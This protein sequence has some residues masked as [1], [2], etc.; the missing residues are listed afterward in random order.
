[1]NK[2]LYELIKDGCWERDL[3]KFFACRPI[4]IRSLL[5][6]NGWRMKAKPGNNKGKHDV[7]Y[8][9]PVRIPEPDPNK[10]FIPLRSMK[11]I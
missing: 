8:Y 10:P 1:M 7:W 5:T 4:R 6:H 11:D 3:Q 9:D 2:D